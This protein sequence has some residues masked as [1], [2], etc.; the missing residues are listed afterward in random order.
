VLRPFLTKSAGTILKSTDQGKTFTT[1]PLPFKVGG[2]MPGRGAGERLVVDPSNNN[3]LYLG[4]RSGHGLWR[5]TD[6]G[7]TWS[8][9]TSFTAT[10]SYSENPSDT[11]GRSHCTT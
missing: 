7:V 11:T 1:I 10:G 9:V 5:S 8:K 6:A 2:N 4:A 3:L